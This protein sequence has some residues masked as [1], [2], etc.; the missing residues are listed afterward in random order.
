MTTIPVFIDTSSLP[1]HPGRPGA[2]F[3]RLKQLTNDGIVKV[4]LSDVVIKEWRSQLEAELSENIEKAKTAIVRVAKHPW[5]VELDKDG[6]F[7]SASSLL[8]ISPDKLED[9]SGQK[10]NEILQ[11][12]QAELQPV[13]EHHGNLVIDSY[14]AGVLPFKS[15]KSR[16]DFPDAF[17]FECAKDIKNSVENLHCVVADS[18]LSKALSQ[19]EGVILYGNIKDFVQ[20]EIIVSITIQQEKERN[21]QAVLGIIK[22][23]LHE[24]KEELDKEVLDQ[25]FEAIKPWVYHSRI[26]DDN[27]E[28]YVSSVDEPTNIEF[29]WEKIQDFGSGLITL[30]FSLECPA[31][32]E[33][34][35]FRGDAFTIPDEVWVEIVDPEEQH[36]FDASGMVDIQVSGTL[37]I[38][39]DT[40]NLSPDVFPEIEEVKINE[41]IKQ[42]IIEDINGSIFQ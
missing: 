4:Y 36:Y 19:I 13:K 20:S 6:V 14:F 34:S 42:E 28:A 29:D 23:T 15:R 10:V 12:I 40:E 26:P 2:A 3:E 39:F 30:P 8:S 27:N 41:I 38:L 16:E 18:T 25:Y 24:R 37:S 1:R 35:V 22:A 33:F 5:A 7:N 31:S 11:T 17:I 32:I 21:W 9:L